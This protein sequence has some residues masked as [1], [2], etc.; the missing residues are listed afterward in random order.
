MTTEDGS[1]PLTNGYHLAP[2]LS[3]SRTPPPADTTESHRIYWQQ[4]LSSNETSVGTR[5]EWVTSSAAVRI[6]RQARAADVTAL[7]R[8]S[9]H[10]APN[11][12][13]E[14]ALVLVGTLYSLS[15]DHVR[16]THEQTQRRLGHG[17]TPLPSPSSSSTD[18]F[19]VLQT[20]KP[21]DHPLEI[22]DQM[23]V[24]LRALQAAAAGTTM[25]ERR[26][27]IAPKLQW[28][29][30]PAVA[31]SAPPTPPPSSPNNNN[32]NNNKTHMIPTCINLEGY[33]TSMEEEEGD[34][35]YDD[36]EEQDEA[37]SDTKECLRNGEAAVDIDETDS[38][39][40][41]GTVEDRDLLVSR[42]PWLSVVPEDH[43]DRA[44]T[45]PPADVSRY[46]QIKQEFRREN[47]RLNI[48]TAHEA[49]VP[50]GGTLSG[51]LL[52][53]SHKD[54]HV[55]RRVHC[56]LTDDYL[57]FVSRRYTKYDLH[58]AKHG[59]VRLTRALLLEPSVD[60]APLYRTPYA[61]EMVAADGTSHIFRAANRAIQ[62]QWI[63]AISDRIIQSFENSLLENAQLIVNDESVAQARRI[64]HAMDQFW[65]HIQQAHKEKDASEKSATKKTTTTISQPVAQVLRW[66][67]KVTDFRHF[68]RHV[69]SSLPAKSPVVVSTAHV[70]PLHARKTISPTARE[71][72]GE[73]PG[74]LVQ[75]M[76]AASW[77]QAA[78][79]LQQATDVGQALTGMEEQAAHHHHR[80][81]H[82]NLETLLRHVEFLVTGRHR[83]RTASSSSLT[84][85][86][87]SVSVTNHGDDWYADR[88]EPPP[89]D[90]FDAI[91][92]ELQVLAASM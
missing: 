5:R 6:A 43:P 82:R 25:L 66:T 33:C 50:Q 73:A 1:L 84:G 19:N 40:M 35:G 83:P 85:S 67:L 88:A 17:S 90:L 18:A 22:R 11:S 91:E 62:Q 13:Q 51:Y 15:R 76:I 69:R 78:L 70:S 9:L 3:P 79:L 12:K 31:E 64:D 45:R 92:K 4:W 75:S 46:A 77:R 32:N 38:K 71:R 81:H 89:M 68:C 42:F 29:Y 28:Y 59:R 86:Q 87:T 54:R 48:L 47:R 2:P 10:L 49:S 8:E 58:F 57:W 53:R 34:W 61:F 36:D 23:A 14:D 56:V 72:S 44:T 55:W 20:L 7:L 80:H 24:H 16:F 30:C 74:P 26:T 37:P 27:I 41:V 63:Q 65:G 60:Y 21:T 52:K 39:D